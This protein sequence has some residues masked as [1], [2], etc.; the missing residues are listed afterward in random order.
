[1][2]VKYV[3]T[4]EIQ[5]EVKSL[6]KQTR[7]LVAKERL[8]AVSLYVCNGMSM[9]DIATTLGRNRDTVGRWVTSYFQGGVQALE[10]NRGGDHSSYLTDVNKQ[11]LK[12]IIT[13]TYPI[14]YKGW[15]GKIIVDLIKTKYGVTYTRNGVYALLKSLGLTHK[16]ATKIDPKKSEIAIATWKE[17]LKK[18]S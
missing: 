11:E 8:I 5:D 6:L 18:T 16:V 4:Q 13:N 10:D 3:I 2:R 1:M 15:D 7:S 9:K 14:V 12:D 17:E